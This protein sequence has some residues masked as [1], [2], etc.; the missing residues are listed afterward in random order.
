MSSASVRFG[1]KAYVCA[2]YFLR[3]GIVKRYQ[4]R[5]QDL[6]GI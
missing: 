6:S 2:R 3:P 5:G 1:T 4:K